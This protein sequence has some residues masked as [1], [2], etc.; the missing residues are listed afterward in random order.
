MDETKVHHLLSIL[1]SE[2]L[3][4]P[5]PLVSMPKYE[6]LRTAKMAALNVCTRKSCRYL[7]HKGRH[8]WRSCTIV[9]MAGYEVLVNR[10]VVGVEPRHRHT[11]GETRAA[12]RRLA[13][14]AGTAMQWV[15]AYPHGTALIS[16]FSYC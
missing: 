6:S 4:R 8:L 9:Y 14:W 11:S 15:R 16:H 2:K 5:N 7:C 1:S 3:V 12:G 10:I 13:T